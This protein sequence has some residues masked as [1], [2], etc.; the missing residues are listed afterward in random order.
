MVRI[1]L[2]LTTIVID[3]THT[4]THIHTQH[5]HRRKACRAIA[6]N[7]RSH[8]EKRIYGALGLDLD[9]VLVGELQWVDRCWA[10][11]TTRCGLVCDLAVQCC[12]CV[13]VCVCVF[14]VCVVPL[15]CR[16][17]APTHK[18]IQVQ[19]AFKRDGVEGAGGGKTRTD[20][21]THTHTHTHMH[22]HTHTLTHTHSHTHKL[23]PAHLPLLT[24]L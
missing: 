14:C 2:T 23:S 17:T 24:Y 15:L 4:Y 10:T 6:K 11:L 3:C 18:H 1:L 19:R 8:C 7:S 20:T 21:H 9:A 13:C 12:A 5:A 22:T 16:R